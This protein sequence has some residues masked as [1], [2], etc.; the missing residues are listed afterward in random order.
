MARNLRLIMRNIGDSATVTASPAMLATLPA[1]NVQLQE[2]AYLARSSSLADQ[3]LLFDL[4][5]ARLVY[6]D[7]F[8]LIARYSAAA[9]I[10]IRLYS[11]AAQ[12]GTLVYDSGAVS[13]IGGIGWGEFI[14]GVDAWGASIVSEGD[15]Q[16]PFYFRFFDDADSQTSTYL[17]GRID[18]SDALNPAGYHEFLRFF[19]GPVI[20]PRYNAEYGLEWKLD[21]ATTQDAD[22]GGGLHSDPGPM[23]RE[24]SFSLAHLSEGER[25]LFASEYRYCGKTNDVF[26]CTFPDSTGQR[27]FDYAMAAKFTSSPTYSLGFPGFQQTEFT[28]REA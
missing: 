27:Y 2:R 4:T 8:A 6:A 23:A 14:W 12:G 9:T 13:A 24:L 18:V 26:V 20:S 22:D 10:R 16:E 21:D 5:D 15:G 1:T 17:S 7:G 3:A 28:L 19:L 25:S 11:A